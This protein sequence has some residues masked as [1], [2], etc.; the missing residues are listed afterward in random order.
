MIQGT[1]NWLAQRWLLVSIV[2][3][4]AFVWLPWLAPIFMQW[5][6]ESAAYRIYALYSITCHQLPQ[7]SFFLFG[8][9]GSQGM[10][11]LDFVQ[12]AY[13]ETTNLL[14][15]RQFIG[16]P[17]LGWKVAW[18]DR[19]TSFYGG[20]WLWL[21]VW[22]IVPSRWLPRLSFIT[23]IWFAWPMVLDGTTHMISDIMYDIGSGFRDSN[24]WLA[25]LTGDQLSPTF[26]AG[27]SFGTFNSWVRLL[28]GLMFSF[29]L[30]GWGLPLLAVISPPQN[31]TS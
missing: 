5:G 4:G 7:R 18:S 19:M 17:A 30:V 29:G 21:V 8:D 20:I 26:Y 12:Y 28:S 2:V 9:L 1:I 14:E 11:E 13:K 23:F 15:L 22:Y 6:W 25:R 10:Y 27:D 3:W 31:A 24:N 16:S